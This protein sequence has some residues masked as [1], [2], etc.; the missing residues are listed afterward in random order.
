MSD[1]LYRRDLLRLAADAHGAGRLR[2][3]DAT[4]EAFNPACGDR[5]TVNILLA[6]GRISDLAHETKACVLAQASASILGSALRGADC[7][8]VAALH[9]RVSAMLAAGENPPA[10]PFEAYGLFEGAVEYASRHR[11]VLLPIE[12][13]LDALHRS[14]ASDER[15]A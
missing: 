9:A 8:E 15:S 3:P 10:A 5:V 14:V 11:C 12:A 6:G 7:A 1:P 4:G 13:V 2:Q